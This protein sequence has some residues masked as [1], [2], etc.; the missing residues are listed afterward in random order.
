MTDKEI[1]DYKTA[2]E[3]D[4]AFSNSEK[5]LVAIAVELHRIANAL[6]AKNE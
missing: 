2:N 5:A 1:M 3:L 6:E 4:T